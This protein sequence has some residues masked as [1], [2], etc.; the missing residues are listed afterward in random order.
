MRLAN[1]PRPNLLRRLTQ[2]SRLSNPSYLCLRLH[3]VHGPRAFDV[4]L[5]RREKREL[6]HVK[7][8]A[9][10]GAGDYILLNL[11]QIVVGVSHA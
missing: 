7:V 11:N 5:A 9:G 3:T 10:N 8:R 1:S 2:L 4:K 6:A